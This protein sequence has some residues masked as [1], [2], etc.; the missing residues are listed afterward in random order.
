MNSQQ[1]KFFGLLACLTSLLMVTVQADITSISRRNPPGA[2]RD[3][4]RDP[5]RFHEQ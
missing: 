4:T 3:P 1:K 2:P 5:L